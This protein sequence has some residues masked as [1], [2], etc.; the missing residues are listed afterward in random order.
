[1]GSWTEA[2]QGFSLAIQQKHLFWLYLQMCV[3]K[4]RCG[5]W[6]HHQCSAEKGFGREY[7]DIIPPPVTVRSLKALC[8]PLL[9]QGVVNKRFWTLRARCRCRTSLSALPKVSLLMPGKLLYEGVLGMVA[10][11]GPWMAARKNAQ[12]RTYK[13]T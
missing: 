10:Q 8:G 1:M 13:R 9:M 7:G 4:A 5:L 12:M 3:P 6:A 11:K 2:S